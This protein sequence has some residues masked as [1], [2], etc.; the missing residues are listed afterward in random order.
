MKYL[1]ACC[2]LL[3]LLSCGSNPQKQ[4]SKHLPVQLEND[5]FDNQ[6]TGVFIFD[7]ETGDTLFRHNADKYFTPAS[8]T[9]IFTLYTAMELLPELL[10]QLQFQNT[11]DTLYIRGTG[12]PTLLHPVFKEQKSLDLIKGFD[13]IYW[14]ANRMDDTPLGPGWSWAD[15]DAYYSAERSELPLYGNVALAGRVTKDSAW[16]TPSV[17]STEITEEGPD[18]YRDQN[19]NHFYI[20]TRKMEDTLEIPFHT[21]TTT[22]KALLE[23]ALNKSISIKDTLLPGKW[24]TIYGAPADS[25]YKRMMKRSDNFIA[26]QLLIQASGMLGD[27]LDPSKAINYIL[28]GPLK[29]LKTMPRWVDGSGLSRYNLFTPTAMVHVLH[30]LYKCYGTERLFTFF[31]EGGVSGTLKNYFPGEGGPYVHAKTG[32][33]ANNYCLSGYLVTNSGKTLIFS[34]MNNH[35]MGSSIPVKQQMTPILEWVRDHY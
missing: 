8:N 7:P 18:Y 29:E 15:Y 33:L 11:G 4:F 13:T 9:K 28:K 31:P 25:V 30:E 22:V 26:E 21:D 20:H 16:I 24:Q 27:T 2:S 6:F 34:F 10:P 19:A 12:D 32:T 5:F 3:F 17:F 1:I 14:V 23:Q 35:Y